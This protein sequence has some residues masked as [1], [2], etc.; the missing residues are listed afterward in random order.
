MENRSTYA[1]SLPAE[2]KKRYLEK[3][4]IVGSLDPFAGSLGTCTDASDL[5]S[6]LC[7]RPVSLLP[8]NLRYIKVW[9]LTINLCV[10]GSTLGRN[11]E[12]LS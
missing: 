4:N 1:L 6:Y 5:V 11:L 3:I 12:S 10:G 9:N 7:Y 2:A 8:S